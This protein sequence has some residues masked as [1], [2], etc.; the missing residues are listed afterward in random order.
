MP[1]VKVFRGASF[2]GGDELGDYEFPAVPRIGETVSLY[3]DDHATFERVE[4]VNYH[5][6][7][8]G[9]LVRILIKSS[10]RDRTMQRVGI[11]GI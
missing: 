6:G 11:G 1:M 7:T 9:T 2:D 10:P 4:D 5:L 3:A 8:D